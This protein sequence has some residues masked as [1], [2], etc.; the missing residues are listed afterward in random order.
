M[1][2]MFSTKN[3]HTS[4]L[5]IATDDCSLITHCIAHILEA[6]RTLKVVL[7]DLIHAWLRL[8]WYFLHLYMFSTGFIGLGVV[9]VYKDLGYIRSNHT[10]SCTGNFASIRQIHIKTA[11]LVYEVG[12][13]TNFS[14]F[15]VEC[16][17]LY[18]V[19][20]KCIFGMFLREKSKSPSKIEDLNHRAVVLLSYTLPFT[21]PSHTSCRC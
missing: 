6:S 19:N 18:P 14:G 12:I 1:A 4:H 15:S 13:T 20:L 3:A 11:I 7:G 8:L 9:Y 16:V 10:T 2:A 21:Q 17:L 5:A